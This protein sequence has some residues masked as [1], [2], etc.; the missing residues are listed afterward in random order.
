M[1][2]FKLTP[3]TFKGFSEADSTELLRYDQF[4]PY[5]KPSYFGVIN[6][7]PIY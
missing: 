5:K 1:N 4:K 3:W 2:R 7:T 6:L